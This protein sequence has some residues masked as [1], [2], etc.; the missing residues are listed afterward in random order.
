M[1]QIHVKRREQLDKL[2]AHAFEL[3]FEASEPIN[4]T[5]WRYA[6]SKIADA[7]WD[8]S[9]E[10]EE[11]D[12]ETLFAILDQVDSS[13]NSIDDMVECAVRDAIEEAFPEGFK[14]KTILE[15]GVIED[16]HD[17]IHALVYLNGKPRALKGNLF[18]K[19]GPY[20][21]ACEVAHRFNRYQ[22]FLMKQKEGAV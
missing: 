14:V 10:A 5:C 6:I 18:D 15:G 19:T 11:L 9:V 17:D 22:K 8:N 4:Q 21:Y 16:E 12:D 1:N 13:I 2:K 20:W 3:G 7:C